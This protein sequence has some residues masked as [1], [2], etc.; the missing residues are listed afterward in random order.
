MGVRQQQT[1]G[2]LSNVSV[3]KGIG[4]GILAWITTFVLTNLLFILEIGNSDTGFEV[5]DQIGWRDL[6]AVSFG[7]NYYSA[8]P[9]AFDAPEA[10]TAFFPSYDTVPDIVYILIVVGILGL[11]G[12]RMVSNANAH[13]DEIGGAAQG[14]TMAISYA[15]LMGLSVLAVGAVMESSSDIF[16]DELTNI[17]L[18]AGIIYPAAVGGAG[19]VAAVLVKEQSGSQRPA[20]RPP[21]QGQP[22]AG[23]RQRGGQP[24]GA[25]QPR[26]P[27]GGQ[28]PGQPQSAQP[29]GGR[30]PGQ[31]QSAQPQDGRQPGQPKGAQQPGQPQGG[32]QPPADE[33]IS[34]TDE[35]PAS[36]G[37][38]APAGD[39]TTEP[40]GFSANEDASSTDESMTDSDM[41]SDDI[42]DADSDDVGESR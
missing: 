20:G 27:Q 28:Q 3:M 41:G 11:L 26:Q 34:E 38:S 37:D 24:Q 9:G 25:R 35:P 10:I 39:G 23:G 40:D 2:S 6:V 14:A 42:A 13:F 12:Y 31:P 16:S 22:P 33:P 32:Q 5:Y 36:H 1:G 19:G 21:A 29:Q 8:Y 15:V 4:V 30:Q 17:V 7:E 18:V